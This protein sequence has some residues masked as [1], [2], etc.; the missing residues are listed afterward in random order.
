MPF[1]CWV[2]FCA[3]SKDLRLNLRNLAVKIASQKRAT[4]DSRFVICVFCALLLFL[5]LLANSI[6][7][8]FARRTKSARKTR[9]IETKN[10][11]NLFCARAKAKTI[12]L[13][14]AM[15]RRNATAAK[16]PAKVT[17]RKT[18]RALTFRVG[19]LH[20]NCN[21]NFRYFARALLN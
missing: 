12:A 9:L 18:A 1:V 17:R 4:F 3:A 19:N 21:A 14:F 6:S 10:C 11:E 15:L 20:C 13:F 7:A 5:C 16:K 8:S 2:R